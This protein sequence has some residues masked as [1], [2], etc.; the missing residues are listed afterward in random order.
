M[1][2]AVISD[3]HANLPALEAVLADIETCQ[4]QALYCLG[5]LVGYAPW[6]NEVV[7]TIWAHRIPTI[8]GNYDHGVGLASDDCGCAYQT[9][10]D[11]AL[12]AES[13]AYT[14][15][16]VTDEVRNYLRTLPRHLE[17]T[18]GQDDPASKLLMVHGS[19]GA[20]TSTCLRTGPTGAC[21]G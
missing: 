8:A 3:V 1:K 18:L 17:L 16:V 19:P 20:S 11:Q 6:P 10:K 14:N 13:I 15:D 12:G 21:C 7:Q 5:D 4:V 9:E 2:L